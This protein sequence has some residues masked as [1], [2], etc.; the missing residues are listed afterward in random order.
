MEWEL[1]FQSFHN[2][3]ILCAF[4]IHEFYENGF[5]PNGTS[6]FKQRKIENYDYEKFN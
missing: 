1:S 6:D 2:E 4:I 3:R 5:L